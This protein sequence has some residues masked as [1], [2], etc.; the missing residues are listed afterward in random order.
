MKGK[1]LTCPASSDNMLSFDGGK[2]RLVFASLKPLT[3]KTL[4]AQLKDVL[5]QL[6]TLVAANGLKVGDIVKAVVF[7]RKYN[8][9][10]I[11]QP[12]LQDYFESAVPATSFII[13]PPAGGEHVALEIMAI[14]GE[15]V[16]LEKVSDN[17]TIVRDSDCRWA[18]V[19]GIEPRNRTKNTFSQ[20]NDCF[21]QMQR[22]LKQAGFHFNQVVRTWLYER[23]IVAME[24]NGSNTTRQRY[25]ILNDV[26]RQF[27]TEGNDGKP[28]TFSHD[29]PP[30][31]TGIGMS[32]GT[33][34]ME[35]LALD[36]PNGAIEIAPLKN[37]EQIDAHAYTQEVLLRGAA[38]IKAAP[39]FS[40]GMSIRKDYR[41]MLISG[42]ASIKGQATVWVDDPVGQARTTLENIDL[43]LQQAQ[44][45]LKDVQQLRIYIKNSKR[46]AELNQR[47]AAIQQV[48]EATLPNIPKLFLIGDVCRDNLLV[49]IEA[50]SFVKSAVSKTRPRNHA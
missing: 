39:L 12:F 22:Q 35:C 8:S 37:P 14:Q 17:L 21:K 30:A 9:K 38:A 36:V 26:R 11:C 3:G 19:G 41:M 10:A 50:L 46:K 29:L 43:V 48:V 6:T 42:T 2:N 44:A 13:Q 1:M 34:V 4:R 47:I 18:Y 20:A 49:E 27:F 28:F 15:N 5:Q 24:K 25:Q 32:E 31:S 40:R 23:D 7:L 16:K 45:S 33:F